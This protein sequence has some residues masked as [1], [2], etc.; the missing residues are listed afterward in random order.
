MNM[1]K[2]LS[3]NDVKAKNTYT[4]T[5]HLAAP[6]CASSASC[7]CRT[8]RAVS[9]SV[10]DK[11]SLAAL[12][13]YHW[14]LHFGRAELAMPVFLLAGLEAVHRLY[15]VWRLLVLPVRERAVIRIQWETCSVLHTTGKYRCH[16]ASTS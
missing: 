10:V 16:S 13:R 12:Q 8:A 14:C 6:V 9:F 1:R 3:A 11:V 5:S 4:K 15:E 2:E 7:S